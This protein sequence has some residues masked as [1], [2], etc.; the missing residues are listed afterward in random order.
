M[1]G[2]YGGVDPSRRTC[3]ETVGAPWF[4]LPQAIDS[5]GCMTRQPAHDRLDI[6]PFWKVQGVFD[7]QGGGADFSYTIGLWSRG[8]PELHLWARPSLGD[9]PGHDWA[10]SM[11]D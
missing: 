11:R 9:D 10:F 4:D 7:P 3:S 1:S 6:T 5:G 8:S 2:K